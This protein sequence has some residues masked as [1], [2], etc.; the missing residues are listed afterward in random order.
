MNLRQ[1]E[2][3]RKQWK[4]LRE[5]RQWSQVRLAEALGISRRTVQ[6]VESG[7][8]QQGHFACIP[9]PKTLAKFK[10]LKKRS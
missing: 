10:Q 9:K 4:S 8:G 5:K 6:Y 7:N 1:Q 3:M 2:V